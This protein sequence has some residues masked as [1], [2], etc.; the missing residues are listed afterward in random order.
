MSIRTRLFT[1]TAALLVALS[2]GAAPAGAATPAC[3]ATCL[4]LSSAAFGSATN[5]PFVLADAPK[6]ETVNQPLTLAKASNT[7][8]G[9]DFLL[10]F[11]GVV[12]DFVAAGLMAQQ[13]LG[14]YGNLQAF[15]FE[16]S[17]FGLQ[18]GLCVGVPTTPANGTRVELEPCGVTVKTVWI[19]DTNAPVAPPD[20]PFIQGAT[21]SNFLDPEVL[22]TPLPGQPLTTS[23][24]RITSN[25]S[26]SSNQMWGEKLGVL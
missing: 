17:P 11:Q 9:E 23:A 24:L 20:V 15:E 14:P 10:S 3:G 2:A 7:N 12:S 5:P 16:Y 1:V 4:D 6:L 19:R 18:T 13:M 21:S 22:T 25:G 26:F 8:Q